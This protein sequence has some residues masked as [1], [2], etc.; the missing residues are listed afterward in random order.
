MAREELITGGT[1][2]EHLIEIG[3]LPEG[4]PTQRVIIDAAWDQALMV[5]IQNIGTTKLL[6]MAPPDVSG[7]QVIVLDKESD[8][9][10]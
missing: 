9:T 1:F 6:N 8:G 5:Y 7:M 10:A 3:F 2:L 4:S